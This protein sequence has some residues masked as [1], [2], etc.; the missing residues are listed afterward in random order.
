MVAGV[1]EK[2]RTV[3]GLEMR[4]SCRGIRVIVERS[5]CIRRCCDVC[6]GDE[7][8]EQA[9]GLYILEGSISRSIAATVC[10]A[11]RDASRR[12][13]DDSGR[14]QRLRAWCLPSSTRNFI[15][16]HGLIRQM[17]HLEKAQR[18]LNPARTSNAHPL[19]SSNLSSCHVIAPLYHLDATKTAFI[20]ERHITRDPAYVARL[21]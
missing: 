16:P 9:D 8:W 1:C 19:E 14:F 6:S 12:L 5:D 7:E 20:G 10:C 11:R 18:P 17:R 13:G 4:L 3:V 2:C 21:T 15:T